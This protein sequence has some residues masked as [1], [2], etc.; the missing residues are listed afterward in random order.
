MTIRRKL[1]TIQLM[2]AAI[3]LVLAS[4]V[5]VWS[6][7]VTYRASL[8]S[9][10][11]SYAEMIGDN[12]I[13][14]LEFADPE[15][16]AEILA[17]L[18]VSE[19]ITHA[20]IYDPSGSIF[21][22]YAREQTLDDAFPDTIGEGHRFSE[23]ALEL[24]LP[25]RREGEF[26]STVFIRSNLEAFAEKTTEFAIDASLVLVVGLG[27]SFVLSVVL[28]RT[29][30]GRIEV[31][32]AAAKKVSESGQYDHR[33][34][35]EGTDELG[36]LSAGF[37][38]M[39]SQIQLRD[40]EL[41]EARDTLE[42]R[43]QQRTEELEVARNEALL[44]AREAEAA[45]RSK[46]VFLANVSHE[47]RTPMN[48]ITGFAEIL[49]GMIS[50]PQQKTY[51][52]SIRSSGDDLLD[53]IGNIIDLSKL[54]AGDLDLHYADVD[55]LRVFADIENLFGSLADK[56]QLAFD[57]QL[58][59]ELPRSVEL[60]ERRFVQILKNLLDNALKFTK[61]GEVS[62][63]VKAASVQKKMTLSIKIADTGIGIPEDEI[64][65]VFA[66][67]TQRQGQSINEY[68]GTGLGLT[69]TKRILDVMAGQITVTSK[70]DVGSSFLVVLNDVLVTDSTPIGDQTLAQV[71]G[72]NSGASEETSERAA[73]ELTD[74]VREKLPELLGAVSEKASYAAGLAETLTIN[75]VEEFATWLMALGE[76]YGLSLLVTWAGQLVQQ[77][78]MFEMDDM[79][80]TLKS[81]PDLMEDIRTL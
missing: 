61:Q 4:T 14:S 45:N 29:L 79:A 69:L 39:L 9:R 23:D 49:E 5:F 66:P 71:S 75:E 77:A 26:I 44:M 2:T 6:D 47:I 25:I 42:E 73:E 1:I 81:Y 27:L 48:A 64:D 15:S 38:E 32:S 18:S 57:L 20:C 76:S 34:P 35:S 13:S 54:E 58:D 22:T 78:S 3:V 41:R 59:P 68:G 55:L 7:L 12:T 10:L 11:G 21:A 53:L 74:A 72:I 62:V 19:G 51:L 8:V 33:V 63:E 30:S 60:D 67:F 46:S 65:K 52:E 70:V 56:K 28:Q 80:K 43:V 16:A 36:V 31:L 37:N 50:D 17:S 40:G 24:Y